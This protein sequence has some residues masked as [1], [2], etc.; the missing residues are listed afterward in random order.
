QLEDSSGNEA[1]STSNQTIS[2]STTSTAGA[3]YTGTS[4]GN[5]ITSV[6]ITAGNSSA[7]FYYTDA[8]PGA[9]KVTASDS[10]LNSASNQ[11]ETDNPAPAGHLA[12]ASAPL[13]L[14]AGTWGPVTVQ[15]EDSS[16][17]DTVATSDEAI[18]LS[19]TSTGGAFYAGPSGG[20]PITSIVI[21]TGSG[22]A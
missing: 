22:S 10:K 15:L 7:T 21:S 16:G 3:F 1:V 13:V 14:A 12:I 5:P 8:Q 19:T 11:T 4:G 2:L 20:N 18:D 9:P 6:V 17:N